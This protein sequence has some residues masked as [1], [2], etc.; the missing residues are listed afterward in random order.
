MDEQE[1]HNE[2]RSVRS[3]N[4]NVRTSVNFINRTKQ[5]ARAWWLDYSGHPV[6]YGDIG[7]NEL[8]SMTT[9]LTHPWVFRASR[10]GAKLLANQLGVY[11]PT[12]TTEYEE[13][14]D[15]KFLD[16]FITTPVYSLQEYCLVLIRKLVQEE[17][18][19]RLEIPEALRGELRQRPDLLKELEVINSNR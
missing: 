19:G 12:A 17:D 1:V 2:T 9:Y 6:S 4:A 7:T 11:M 14:E 8:L 18:I 15:P 3:L 5:S 10:N 16:V 13:D